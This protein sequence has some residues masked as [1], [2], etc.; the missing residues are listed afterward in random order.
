MIGLAVRFVNDLI[1]CDFDVLIRTDVG[2][3]HVHPRLR[4]QIVEFI[5]GY[6]NGKYGMR[7][8][9]PAFVAFG[10]PT[11]RI[12]MVV[13]L[14]DQ[15]DLV[16]VLLNHRQPVLLQSLVDAVPGP[17]KYGMMPHEYRPVLCGL[18]QHRIEPSPLFVELLVRI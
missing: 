8:M 5:S 11:S 12:G 7:R 6:R 14:Q 13:P 1:F 9:G 18:V 10:Q 2:N 4:F 3:G 16:A 17:R 15:S